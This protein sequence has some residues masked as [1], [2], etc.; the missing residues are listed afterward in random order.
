QQPVTGGGGQ[1]RQRGNGGFRRPLP[2]ERRHG[3]GGVLQPVAG[4]GEVGVAVLITGSLGFLEAVFV[5]D[6]P[7]G[8]RCLQSGGALPGSDVFGPD[9]AQAQGGRK[10]SGKQELHFSIRR[11]RRDFR[12]KFLM[13]G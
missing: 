13:R 7:V 11:H 2:V 4:G 1:R 5:P 10:Q 9:G 3:A 6:W 8:K 12:L